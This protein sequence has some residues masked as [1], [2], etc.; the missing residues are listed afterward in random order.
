[1]V[2]RITSAM[3][4]WSVPP[5]ESHIV[6]ARGE[7]GAIERAR[8]LPPPAAAAAVCAGDREGRK[9]TATRCRATSRARSPRR[10][11][12]AAP[13]SDSRSTCGGQRSDGWDT[14]GVP[15]LQT[16]RGGKRTQLDTFKKRQNAHSSPM[17]SLYT[18][19]RPIT[20]KKI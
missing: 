15:S 4:T 16:G 10:R 9:L 3:E 2:I 12:P 14:N 13:A 1:M 20:S 8:Y 6:S 17:E 7:P 5:A 18:H 11:V 19:Q